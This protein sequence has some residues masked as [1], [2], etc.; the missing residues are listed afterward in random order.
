MNLYANLM[1]ETNFSPMHRVSAGLSLNYDRFDETY[2]L[3]Y[4][5]PDMNYFDHPKAVNDKTKETVAGAYVEYTFNKDDKFILLAGLRGDYSSQYDFFVTPR[6][7]LKYNFTDW[8][9]LRA[10]A[11]KGFRTAHV[12][13]ENNFYLASSR[14]F[15]IAENPDQEEAWNYG[16]N[17]GFYVPVAG[18]ELVLNVEWYYTDF[19]KQVVVDVDTDPRTISLYNLDGKSY[20]SSFQFEA[21]YPFFRGFT[22]TAAYRTMDAKTTYNGVLRKKPFTGDYKGLITASYQTPLRKWQF[23]VTSQ[24]NGGGRMPDA[25]KTNPLWSNSF[26]SFVILNAQVS[27][28]FRTWSI[29]AGSE[30][31]LDFMQK[32]PVISPGSPWERDFDA[33]MIWGPLHGRKF[34]I[35]ARWNLPRI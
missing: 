27:K 3:F 14:S 30:N 19:V 7:H 20:S 6:L 11:G 24:F 5:D 17:L 16:V 21:S 34:Y 23:D 15:N 8:L 22:L 9:H 25:D 29:Y 18:K 35:G 1:Y 28:F 31:L 2:N 33:T 4:A 26:D 32:H 13:P 10:S 12:L